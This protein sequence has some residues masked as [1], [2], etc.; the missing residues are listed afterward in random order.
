MIT[1]KDISGTFA[2]YLSQLKLDIDRKSLVPSHFT[3]LDPGRTQAARL[4]KLHTPKQKQLTFISNYHI[5]TILPHKQTK[6]LKKL[7]FTS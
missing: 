6:Y 7:H 1:K 5:H 4:T 2:K 3:E